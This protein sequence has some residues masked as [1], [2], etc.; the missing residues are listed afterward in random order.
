MLNITEHESKTLAIFA[1]HSAESHGRQYPEE[2]HAWRS[3]FMRDRD[4]VIH[5]SA[6]RRLE[7]KTQVFVIFEGDYYRTRLT[8]TIEVAQ[9]SRTIARGLRLNEELAE[10]IAL[11]HD[12]GHPPFG[13]SGE[14][15]LHNLMD[16][17]GGFEH[18]SHGLRIVERLETRYPAFPGLNLSFE[19][20]EGI[21][22]HKTEYDT[23]D[24]GALIEQR[25]MPTL[26]AQ[27]VNLAD[28]IT[29]S[30]HDVDDGLKSGLL[31]EESLRT[32]GICKIIYDEMAGNPALMNDRNMRHYQL[33]RKL[34]DRQVNDAITNSLENISLKK[35]KNIA[36]VRAAGEELISFS[37][38]TGALSDEL[39]NYLMINFYRHHRVAAMSNKARRFLKALFE[40]YL[41][42]PDLIPPDNRERSGDV[43]IHRTVCDY[44]A[45]MTDRYALEEYR[46]LFEPY[47]RV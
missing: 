17:Y 6:F 34:I 38:E 20:R 46:R 19:V 42:N 35:I 12:L 29:Y 14:M 31:N 37:P 44:I 27:V 32:V 30:C 39:H 3:P 1:Q 9:I 23:P 21:A 10:A 24:A 41:E 40:A 13:H 16:G 15:V 45:G 18:N 43:S 36:D 7:S 26:E 4:R 8:H 5:S 33:I 25:G 47:E 11:A 28:E 2:E 22:K